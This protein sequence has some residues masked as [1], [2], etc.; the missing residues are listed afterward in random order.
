MGSVMRLG[1]SP[2][3]A[4]S[5][6]VLGAALTV[7]GPQG[8]AHCSARALP[9]VPLLAL[10]AAGAPAAA[11][12]RDVGSAKTPRSKARAHLQAR[13]AQHATR[14]QRTPQR[15]SAERKPGGPKQP[16]RAETRALPQ[17]EGGESDETSSVRASA[18]DRGPSPGEPDTALEEPTAPKRSKR[19]AREELRDDEIV[20][21]SRTPLG[22]PEAPPARDDAASRS[23]ASGRREPQRDQDSAEAASP[24][25]D[26]VA[27]TRKPSAAPNTTDVP[28]DVELDRAVRTYDD[29]LRED[30][31]SSSRRKKPRSVTQRSTGEEGPRAQSASASAATTRQSAPTSATS[32]AAEGA[33]AQGVRPEA[34]AKPAGPAGHSSA[35][36]PGPQPVPPTGNA[37]R[38]APDRAPTA[39]APTASAPADHGVTPAPLDADDLRDDGH[40]P[41]A[42]RPDMKDRAGPGTAGADALKRKPDDHDDLRNY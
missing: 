30:T 4:V 39:K 14:A 1:L 34:A 33:L 13:K 28:S 11:D 25:T 2:M 20:T 23:H 21:S 12:P 36:S 17:A 9:I 41:S 31:R 32:P 10:S 38:A 37:E 27:R 5:F 7:G 26:R 35:A 42:P 3:S 22:P 16:Q 6:C 19:R 24:S 8:T 15:K 40:R 18:K 29:D